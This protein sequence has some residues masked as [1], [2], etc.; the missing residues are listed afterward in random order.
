MEV[1]QVLATPVLPTARQE[2]WLYIII[3]VRPNFSVDDDGRPETDGRRGHQDQERDE[4]RSRG[5]STHIG[6]MVRDIIPSH[7]SKPGRNQIEIGDR[8]RNEELVER[9]GSSEVACVEHHQQT[10]E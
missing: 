8:S 7:H 4:E 10:S 9:F 3:E 6:M 2:R 5:Q 1:T